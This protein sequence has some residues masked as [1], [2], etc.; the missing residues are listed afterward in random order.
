MLP[1]LLCGCFHSPENFIQVVDGFS[2]FLFFDWTKG[3][4]ELPAF[5]E[6]IGHFWLRKHSRHLN[7]VNAG[8]VET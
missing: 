5:C 8:K 4:Q 6:Q 2:H 3:S 7:I 1:F